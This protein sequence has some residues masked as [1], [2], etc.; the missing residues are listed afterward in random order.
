MERDRELVSASAQI[1]RCTMIKS[2]NRAFDI[3]L[4]TPRNII[5][6]V[7]LHR[8]YIHV[9]GNHNSIN[10]IFKQVTYFPG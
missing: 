4:P 9:H 8:I 10:E 3:N 2:Q 6:T 5:Q 1:Y 7:N